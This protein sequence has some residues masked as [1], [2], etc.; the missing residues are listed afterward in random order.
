MMLMREGG[1]VIGSWTLGVWI[2][3]FLGIGIWE[4]RPR[5]VARAALVASH[6]TNYTV[7][8]C[9]SANTEQ[10]QLLFL[11]LNQEY[12]NAWYTPTFPTLLTQDKWFVFKRICPIV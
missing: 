10:I 9:C 8:I 1:L 12:R 7:K 4:F 2:I 6:S 5:A 11:G 3:G